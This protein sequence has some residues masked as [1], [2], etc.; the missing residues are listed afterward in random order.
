[1]KKGFVVYSLIL[2]LSLAMVA[3]SGSGPAAEGTIGLPEVRQ[4]TQESE[5]NVGSWDNPPEMTIDPDAIYQAILKT[6]KGDI[7]IELFTDLA[8]DT[9]NNFIFL[10]REGF[11][12]PPCTG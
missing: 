8:P 2:G 9:V 6:D 10:A 5:G 4:P 1:M 3:C 7:R 11:Y 12:L